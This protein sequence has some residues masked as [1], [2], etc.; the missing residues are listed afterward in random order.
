MGKDMQYLID[1][2]PVAYENCPVG[3]MATSMKHW[4]ETGVAGPNT[5][6]GHLAANRLIECVEKAD[7]SNHAALQDWAQWLRQYAPVGS[8]GSEEMARAWAGHKGLSGWDAWKE[9]RKALARVKYGVDA[10]AQAPSF[11]APG[12]GTD[13]PW[14]WT[15]TTAQVLHHHIAEEDRIR[16]GTIVYKGEPLMPAESA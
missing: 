10:R 11:E 16:I 14:V 4:I 3:W 12:I 5:F 15:P 6:I 9:G 8:Y 1:G 2:K 7:P 13:D